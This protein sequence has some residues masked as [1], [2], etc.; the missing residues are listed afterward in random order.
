MHINVLILVLYQ[1]LS[2]YHNG[3]INILSDE[4]MNY[5]NAFP[6]SL[7]HVSHTHYAS[8][9]RI[10]LMHPLFFYEYSLQSVN[11]MSRST[12]SLF[13]KMEMQTNYKRNMS[14]GKNEC[15][16]FIFLHCYV[17]ILYPEVTEQTETSF[18]F[19]KT[20]SFFISFVNEGKK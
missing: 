8:L 3:P 17:S 7:F 14:W 5:Y 11:F 13:L 9:R 1:L 15:V 6:V 10:P 12:I 18:I 19:V 2:L 20:S 4:V 16:L